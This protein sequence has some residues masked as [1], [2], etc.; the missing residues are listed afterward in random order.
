MSEFNPQTPL[1][2]SKIID[3]YLKL[4]DKKYPWVNQYD[5]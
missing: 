4:L 1:Y 2:N 3:I 5:L